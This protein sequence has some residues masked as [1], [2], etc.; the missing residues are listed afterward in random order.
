MHHNWGSAVTDDQSASWARAKCNKWAVDFPPFLAW[1]AHH[2]LDEWAVHRNFKLALPKDQ[3]EGARTIVLCSNRLS[4][5]QT[6]YNIFS[7]C[8]FMQYYLPFCS[9]ASYCEVQRLFCATCRASRFHEY[10]VHCYYS[11]Q[12]LW[13]RECVLIFDPIRTE[14]WG[15]R[16]W[17]FAHWFWMYVFAHWFWM[18]VLLNGVGNPPDLNLRFWREGNTW[19]LDSTIIIKETTDP[20]VLFWYI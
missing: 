3:E 13:E 16:T 11:K 14:Y 4:L 20:E 5:S 2:W 9:L 12:H 10:S 17:R 8:S 18:Y 6:Y 7:P 15:H 19:R 1:L